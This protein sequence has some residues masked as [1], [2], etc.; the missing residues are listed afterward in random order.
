MREIF[1]HTSATVKRMSILKHGCDVGSGACT[2]LRSSEILFE[3]FLVK[4]PLLELRAA[5]QEMC[6]ETFAT[7]N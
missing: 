2:L 4:T 6:Y 3:L 5:K 7:P 1:Q